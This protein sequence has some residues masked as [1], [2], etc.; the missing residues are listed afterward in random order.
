MFLE[1]FLNLYKKGEVSKEQAERWIQV[2]GNDISQRM[3]GCETQSF[4]RLSLTEINNLLFEPLTK[5][6]LEKL[7]FNLDEKL[8]KMTCSNLTALNEHFVSL[9]TSLKPIRD[10]TYNQA[11]SSYLDLLEYAFE[12]IENCESY[13]PGT[14]IELKTVEATTKYIALEITWESGSTRRSFDV[15]FDSNQ[16]NINFFWLSNDRTYMPRTYKRKVVVPGNFLLNQ[17]Y[18]I[19]AHELVHEVSID[20]DK[21]YPQQNITT[22][23]LEDLP[24][25]APIDIYGIYQYLFPFAINGVRTRKLPSQ[26]NIAEQSLIDFRSIFSSEIASAPVSIFLSYNKDG[27]SAWNNHPLINSIDLSGVAWNVNQ[28]GTL[29]SRQHIVYAKHYQGG[30]IRV[31]HDRNGNRVV[32]TIVK[33]ESIP[34]TDI[35]IA[36]L[37]SPVPETVKHYKFVYNNI[38]LNNVAYFNNKQV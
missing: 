36:L 4:E 22:Y 23:S 15:S 35:S 11:P 10:L 5:D 20:T 30:N 37:D 7:A 31:F 25:T 24:V 17:S 21:N 1:R 33:R 26:E 9:I 2:W 3:E 19:F 6:T 8:I 38:D 18:T 13:K 16:I 12:F 28:A 32:R 34:N 27:T 14:L 29:I